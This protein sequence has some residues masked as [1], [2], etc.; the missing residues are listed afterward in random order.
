LRLTLTAS[1]DA[2]DDAVS[3]DFGLE[4]PTVDLPETDGKMIWRIGRRT[5]VVAGFTILDAKKGAIAAITIDFILRRK[6][7]IESRLSRIPG[8]FSG[9]RVTKDVIE[10]VRVT[11]LTD[12]DLA[13]ERSPE[14]ERDWQQV[15]K[16]C[17]S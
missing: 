13:T 5:D 3:V 6:R 12:S 11:A 10:A 2:E 15:V 1:Y 7:D 9:G 8:G 16:K 14:T 17:Q 4:E